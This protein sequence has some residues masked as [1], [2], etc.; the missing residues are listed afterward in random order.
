M[1]LSK[2][3]YRGDPI[4]F[5][6]KYINGETLLF[7][8]LGYYFTSDCLVYKYSWAGSKQTI[9][10]SQGLFLSNGLKCQYKFE[11]G[12]LKIYTDFGSK[13]ETITE[14]SLDDELE[15]GDNYKKFRFIE[16]DTLRLG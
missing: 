11:F 3:Y 16:W 15:F 6:E 9:V 4:P 7:Y 13:F 1:I 5:S 8:H 10:M 12:I 2:G 14:Y